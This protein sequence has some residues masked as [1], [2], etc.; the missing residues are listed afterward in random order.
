MGEPNDLLRGAR[1]RNESPHAS[2]DC[3]SREELAD[4]VNAWLF[5]HT[6]G[7]RAELDGN[8]IGK[9]EQGR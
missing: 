2:G 9:L 5:E 3:L 8:Y 7:R 4:L 1:E 6:G